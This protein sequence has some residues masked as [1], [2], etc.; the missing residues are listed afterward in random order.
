MKI[1]QKITVA[2]VIAAG[3]PSVAN[4]ALAMLRTV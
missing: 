3:S 4:V 1:D 2:E